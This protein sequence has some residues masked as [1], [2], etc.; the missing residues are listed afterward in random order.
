M[1]Y[2]KPLTI[3]FFAAFV[4][5]PDTYAQEAGMIRLGI[6]ATPN[7]SWITSADNPNIG[8]EQRNL[9]VTIGFQGEY[10]FN[11][12]F[13]L[14]SGINLAFNQGGKLS[15]G[16]NY[17]NANFFTNSDLTGFEQDLA[18]IKN[19]PM[20]R[21]QYHHQYVELPLSIKMR[22]QEL[23]SSLMHIFVHA[24]VFTFG[25]RTQGRATITGEDGDGRAI[26][27]SR[28][29]TTDDAR[30]LNISWGVGGGVEYLP[31]DERTALV[32]GV[33][34][35]SG[36]LDQTRPVRVDN[37]DRNYNL[38]ISNLGIRLGVLF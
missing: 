20:P 28:I 19:D 12:V 13:A 36:M 22:S 27:V 8:M 38:K 14:A 2:L 35:Q 18:T 31:N 26:D 17:D 24:P 9:A 5:L 29:N 25:F 1:R 11:Q 33:F 16:G 6:H 37:S 30:L 21:V 32:L 34:F 15:Y 3:L 4:F 10:Y 23:G 7:L